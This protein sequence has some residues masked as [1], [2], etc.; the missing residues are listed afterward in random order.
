LGGI[1]LAPAAAVSSAAPT[2]QLEWAR[3]RGLAR[4]LAQRKRWRECAEVAQAAR[5][6]AADEHAPELEA[7]V[8][9]AQRR[10]RS[11]RG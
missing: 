5:A 2:Q 11:R 9:R 6:L 8:E 4:A 3:L 10:S 1:E 7:L